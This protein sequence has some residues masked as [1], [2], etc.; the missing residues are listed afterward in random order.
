MKKGDGGITVGWA[1]IRGFSTAL[2]HGVSTATAGY[3]M[4]YVKKKKKLFHSGTFALLMV[5][6]INHGIFNTLVQTDEYK[7]LGFILPM[8]VYL[9][10]SSR[11]LF[12]PC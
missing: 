8:L 6:C 12:I 10:L 4:S 9:P 3:G 1:I 11:W 2:M 5:A 7:F